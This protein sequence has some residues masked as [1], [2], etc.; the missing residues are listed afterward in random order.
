MSNATTSWR[1][2]V[3]LRVFSMVTTCLRRKEI[4]PCTAKFGV[5]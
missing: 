4:T 3:L 2:W 1:V 5:I